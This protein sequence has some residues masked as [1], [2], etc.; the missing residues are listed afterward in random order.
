MSL[1]TYIT[2]AIYGPG[3]NHDFEGYG[4]PLTSVARLSQ[5]LGSYKYF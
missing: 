2:I 5:R 4:Y 3:R 1:A